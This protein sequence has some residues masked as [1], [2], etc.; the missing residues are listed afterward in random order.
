MMLRN[1]NRRELSLTDKLKVIRRV[2]NG[3]TK[4]LALSLDS[5]FQGIR[6]QRS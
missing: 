1:K 3:E 5:I 2:E 6:Y 4:N